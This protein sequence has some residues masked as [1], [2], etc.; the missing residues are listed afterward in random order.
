V[1]L[2]AQ[3]RHI[4]AQGAPSEVQSEMGHPWSRVLKGQAPLL[5]WRYHR[6]SGPGT[7]SRACSP[8]QYWLRLQVAA[9]YCVALCLDNAAYKQRKDSAQCARHRGKS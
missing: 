3:D 5:M 2:L 8:A 7:S 6:L 9:H 4:K 1:V